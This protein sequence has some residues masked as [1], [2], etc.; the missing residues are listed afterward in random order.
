LERPLGAACLHSRVCGASDL[1]IGTAPATLERDGNRGVPK[2]GYFRLQPYDAIDHE[3]FKRLD[4]ADVKVLNWL[5]STRASL[6]YLS[7]ASGVGKSSLLSAAVLPQLRDA[8]WRVVETRI[9]GNPIEG[10]RRAVLDAKDIFKRKPSNTLSMDDVLKSAAEAYARTHAAPLLLVIDQFEEF[11]ILHD[12]AMRGPFAALLSNLAKRPVDGLRLL[13]V[14]R[15][16]YHPLI[17]KLDLP[18]L[19]PNENWYALA[20]YGRSEATSFLEGSGRELSTQALDALF[21][22]LDRLEEARGLYRPIT[23]N[24][25]GLVIESMGA[26]LIGAPSKLI[27]TYLMDSLTASESRDFAKTLLAEMITDAGTKVPLSETQL[28]IKTR[29]EPWQVKATLA[30]L[31]RRALVRRL[32]GAEPTWEIAHD[33]LARVIGQLIGRLKPTLMGRIRPLIAP[34]VLLA[35]LLVILAALPPWQ[36]RTIEKTLRENFGAGFSAE[37]DGQGIYVAFSNIDDRK[38]EDAVPLLEKLNDLSGLG[39]FC[40][41]DVSKP[42]ITSLEPIKRLTNLRRVTL[43]QVERVSLEPLKRL[44]NLTLLVIRSSIIDPEPLKEL[45]NL[46]L[47]DLGYVRS[48]TS[49]ELLEGLNKLTNLNLS[50]DDGITSLE[51]LEGLN[52][53][54]NL[55]L[56]Y[57]NGITSLEPL[58][59]LTN[60]TQLDLRYVRGVTS[61]EP[62]KGL[63]NLRKLDLS[64]TGITSLE[65]LEGMTNLTQLDLSDATGIASLEPLEGM[66]NLTKLDLSGATEI[67][68]L[69]PLKGLTNLRQLD[70]RY[71]RGVESLEPLRGLTNLR[72]LDLKG[73]TGITSLEPLEGM[74]L[75][76]SG[77]SRRQ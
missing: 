46:T 75:E 50:Y 52:K 72:K 38:F 48:V 1:T 54:T 74:K 28:A 61:L 42:T 65:P 34:T 11:L 40:E 36:Q 45:T 60:L 62:L 9:F 66:T 5:K 12:E 70:L 39:L 19:A 4:G 51:P 77:A 73:A 64:G 23:L 76:I 59:G 7:G 25:I 16:D 44:P 31:A 55:N 27:Q 53:L 22:G 15:T 68:N 10:L 43:F 71:D 21:R 33:F 56:S 20:P 8:G 17:F 32:D 3:A 47:L 14:F 13:L 63:T 41:R 6:L 58:K 24:M 69:E 49:L 29:F 18:S 35:W 37:T 2:P 26:K 57:D 30:N 67:T